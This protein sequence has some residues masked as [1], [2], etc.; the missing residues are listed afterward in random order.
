MGIH[1]KRALLIFY[2]YNLVFPSCI[3]NAYKYMDGNSAF[4]KFL[5]LM[6][7]VFQNTSQLVIQTTY[8]IP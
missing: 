6:I 2:K 8:N 4:E 1:L 5:N 3:F 7:Q